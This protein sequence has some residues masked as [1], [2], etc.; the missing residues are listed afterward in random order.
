MKTK[1]ILT[2]TLAVMTCFL[3]VAAQAPAKP[4]LYV[5]KEQT[6]YTVQQQ[7]AS[8]K[9]YIDRSNLPQQDA[10]QLSNALVAAYNALQGDVN[11]STL[12]KK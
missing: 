4:K 12:N 6:I 7:I 10:K 5:I 3:Y 1:N 9:E 2:L 8:V 11:D